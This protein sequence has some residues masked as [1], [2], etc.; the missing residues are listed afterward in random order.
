MKCPHC[1]TPLLTGLDFLESDEAHCEPCDT[2]YKV[3]VIPT[4]EPEF[5]SELLKMLKSQEM[6]ARE[7]ELGHYEKVLKYVEDSLVYALD[8]HIIPEEVSA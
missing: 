5:T 2:D 8:E 6:V 4:N 7:L 1:Y 3:T